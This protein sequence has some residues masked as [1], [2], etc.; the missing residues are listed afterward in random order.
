M[1]GLI[2]A[3]GSLRRIASDA[4]LLVA[5]VINSAGFGSVQAVADG[6]RFCLDPFGDGQRGPDIISL[7]LGT[8]APPLGGPGAS[9]AAHQAL[10]RCVVVV[11]LAAMQRRAC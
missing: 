7:L 11:A 8:S 4:G 6:I 1:A 3:N 10:S 9:L 2:A 5:K